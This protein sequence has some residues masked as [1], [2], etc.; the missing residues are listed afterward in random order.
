MRSKPKVFRKRGAVRGEGL[1]LRSRESRAGGKV[2]YMLMREPQIVECCGEHFCKE[3]IE[4]VQKAGKPCP[5]CQCQSFKIFPQKKVERTIQGLEVSCSN[6]NQG[7]EWKGELRNLEG[8]INLMGPSKE[9]ECK[10]HK[11]P[12]SLGCGEYHERQLI[13]QHETESCIK[14]STEQQSVV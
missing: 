12:C 8:H 14:R 5:L 7:C 4:K 13:Q 9:D 6:K 11:V 2:Y 1:Q 10:Y 3:C